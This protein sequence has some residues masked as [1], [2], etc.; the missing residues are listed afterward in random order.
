MHALPS[1]HRVLNASDG[2][3]TTG[4]KSDRC[5]QDCLANQ[6]QPPRCANDQC[7]IWR[8]GMPCALAAR[9]CALLRCWTS[10]A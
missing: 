1:E 4:W 8:P 2:H 6:L 10:A 3:T 9:G 7:L 5:L